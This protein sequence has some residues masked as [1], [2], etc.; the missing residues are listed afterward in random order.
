[1]KIVIIG[2]G[3]VG[4][5]ICSQLAR[6]GHDITVVDRDFAVL[7]ELSN[8]NDVFGVVG[9]GAD[10]A[11]LKKAEVDKADLVIAV[12]SSDEINILCCSAS[13]KLGAKHTVARVRNPEYTDLMQLLRNDMNLSLTINPELAAAKEVYR[14]LKFPAAAKI[15]TFF[16]GRVELAQFVVSKDSPLCGVTLN[17][18]RNKLN[19]RFLVCG[20]LRNG[21]A[22]IPTGFFKIEAG[23]TVCV[24]APDEE[25]TR[26]FKAIGAYKNPVK[27]VLIVGGGRMTYYL[28]YFLEKSKINSTVI[29]KDPALCQELAQA[30]D[31]TVIN[32]SGTKQ[33]LLLE[34]NLEDTDAFLALSNVDE[35][36]A[37]VSMF[38]KSKN[39]RKVVTLISSISYLELFKGV[40]LD[41]IVS[42]KSST[43]SFILKFVRSLT[44]ARGSEIESLHR[45]MDDKV[46]A[47]E[48]SIKENI[49]R[50]T[51]IPLKDLGPKLKQGVLIACILHNNKVIIP[52][53][54]DI[55]SKG[56]TAIIVTTESQI[57]GIKEILK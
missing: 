31:C 8:T 17:G 6:E 2:G 3:T 26:F 42:P 10:V 43:A 54:N 34:E 38:A 50:I 46:E 19:I 5:A 49:S 53:G 14:M 24:T 27:N 11:T 15:D 9:G 45:V 33:D 37:I 52:T 55:I 28:Q 41:S 29:E 39:A 25:I 48:F 21:E 18:L 1:M 13:K 7:K 51:D 20:V 47:I 35:E 40:G 56:D 57:K 4:S 23:D 16:R 12:T 32:D 22:H 30:Y 44:N 36:N